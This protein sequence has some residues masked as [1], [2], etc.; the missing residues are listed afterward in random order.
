MNPNCIGCGRYHGSVNVHMT[1]LERHLLQAR[2]QLAPFLA[3]IK[4]NRS[5]PDSWVEKLRKGA[6]RG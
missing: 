3:A 5:Q 6:Q 1:C 2:E 4:H